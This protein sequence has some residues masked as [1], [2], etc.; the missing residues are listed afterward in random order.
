MIDG[1]AINPATFLWYEVPAAEWE[2]ALPVGNGRLGAMVFG[3][4]GHFTGVCAR[5]GFELNIYW[6]NG[7]ISKLE[8]HSKYGGICRINPGTAIKAINGRELKQLKINNDGSFEF[9][10]HVGQTYYFASV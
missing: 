3:K 1:I 2:D 9:E 10:T 5:G 8:V 6:Q 7:H 4:T